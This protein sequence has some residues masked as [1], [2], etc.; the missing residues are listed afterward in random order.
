MITR[1]QAYKNFIEENESSLPKEQRTTYKEWLINVQKTGNLSGFLQV[2]KDTLNKVSDDK[3]G[4]ATATASVG[5]ANVPKKPFRPLGLN[6]VVFT[7]GSIVIIS[8]L[9]YVGVSIYKSVKKK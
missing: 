7:I 2:T 5:N 8:G 3:F 1:N 6:P 4:A 9:I